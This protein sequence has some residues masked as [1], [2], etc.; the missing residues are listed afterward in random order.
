MRKT[1]ITNWNKYPEIE[2]EVN[3]YSTGIEKNASLLQNESIPTGNG[4]SYGDASLGE[5]VY[6]S[7]RHNKILHFNKK[8]GIFI[9]QSGILFPE[10]LEVITPHGWFYRLLPEQNLSP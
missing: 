7:L 6:T 2:A 3:F 8:D 1:L 5:R 4:R 9:A 10:I